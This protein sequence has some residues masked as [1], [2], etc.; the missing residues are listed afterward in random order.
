MLLYEQFIKMKSILTKLINQKDSVDLGSSTKTIIEYVRHKNV[1]EIDR[2]KK[3]IKTLQ[4][5]EF[6]KV[7]YIYKGIK[8]P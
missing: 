1:V 6:E 8:P 3:L 5:G 7:P 4:D 2:L